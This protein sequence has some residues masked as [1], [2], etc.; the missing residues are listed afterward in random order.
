MNNKDVKDYP[1]IAGV[2]A[3]NGQSVSVLAIHAVMH[4]SKSYPESGRIIVG[5][6]RMSHTIPGSCPDVGGFCC[7]PDIAELVGLTLLRAAR[8]VRAA[9]GIEVA[10]ARL[11]EE[12]LANLEIASSV[13]DFGDSG[14][15]DEISSLVDEVRELRAKLASTEAAPV[16]WGEGGERRTIVLK[17]RDGDQ[18]IDSDV[19]GEWAAHPALGVDFWTVTHVPSGENVYKAS[20][21]LDAGMAHCLARWLSERIPTGAI[22]GSGELTDVTRQMLR[23]EIS[24]CLKPRRWV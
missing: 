13:G 14:S 8:E 10:R 18:Y 7:S 19:Y 20:G 23:A 9:M 1:H 2:M 15:C 5:S 11:T 21:E 3:D 16:R 17:C 24:A 22:L 6:P 12:Q 4:P